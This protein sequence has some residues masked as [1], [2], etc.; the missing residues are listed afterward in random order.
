MVS[1]RKRVD[2][3]PLLPR[4]KSILTELYGD[5][6]H[7]VVL[8]GSFARDSA[9]EHSDIDIAVVLRGDVNKFKE[10]DRI[11]E[12]LYELEL[13]TGELISTVPMSLNEIENSSWPLYYHIQNEGIR[14]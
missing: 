4:I 13:E 7:D 6:L 1:Y 14:L 3:E 12:V 8:Y 5:R 10:I 11:S 2:I 9:T